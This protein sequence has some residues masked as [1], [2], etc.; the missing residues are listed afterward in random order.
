MSIERSF[1]VEMMVSI[2]PYWDSRKSAV[3]QET[4]KILA[5]RGTASVW[6]HIEHLAS[7][8][9]DHP[10]LH[11]FVC[12]KE[13]IDMCQSLRIGNMRSCSG[14]TAVSVEP[15]KICD[16]HRYVCQ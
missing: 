7:A 1:N 5:H 15:G 14:T 11:H 12:A 13:S 10:E 3:R 16:R 4:S 8:I 2:E 6:I 9:D